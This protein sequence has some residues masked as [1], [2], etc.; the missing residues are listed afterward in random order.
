MRRFSLVIVFHLMILKA[1][2]QEKYLSYQHQ[3]G[4]GE[5]LI[6]QRITNK[7]KNGFLLTLISKGSIKRI[8]KEPG[9]SPALLLQQ[10]NLKE[11]EEN[12]FQH[13]APL[14]FSQLALYRKHFFLGGMY[15]DQ[16]IW[17]I[18]RNRD[19]YSF[20]I[21][22]T[23]VSTGNSEITDVIKGHG[24]EKIIYCYERRGVLTL[25]TYMSG[26]NI[27]NVYQKK[28]DQPVS[29]WKLE[30][31][32]D[33]LNS[34]SEYIAAKKFSDLFAAG[35]FSVYEPGQRCPPQ[36]AQAQTKAFIIPSGIVFAISSKDLVT[37]LIRINIDQAN[38]QIEH[39]K[40]G[41]VL[42]F[43]AAINSFIADSILVTAFIEDQSL[44]V[45]LHHL[46]SENEVQTLRINEKNL[47]SLSSNNIL[48]AGSFLSRTD[49][50]K[51]KFAAF[52]RDAAEN[53]LFV[54]A[55]SENGKAFLSFATQTKTGID[56]PML[57]NLFNLAAF[58]FTAINFPNAHPDLG[59]SSTSDE[60]NIESFGLSMDLKNNRISGLEPDFSTWEKLK[61][62]TLKNNSNQWMQPLQMKNNSNQSSLV[63]FMNGSYYLGHYFPEQKKYLVYRIEEK[64]SD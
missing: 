55:Y 17:E 43:P 21:V 47:D 13:T 60:E 11:E 42:R 1:F 23:D 50:A 45:H 61:L 9:S 5:N 63:F 2:G 37:H 62:F 31:E 22:R 6:I 26:S 3:A 14:S 44:I 51:E 8:K 18:F 33:F 16:Q 40:E 19:N 39:I 48:K 29:Q 25:I 36:L 24:P 10:V 32:K 7:E 4:I 58:S 12:D 27:L 57:M 34:S 30:I 64:G 28:P 49:L 56:G 20:F 52:A 15:Q 53:N 35:H 38:Y 46:Y 59:V 41:R 54:S